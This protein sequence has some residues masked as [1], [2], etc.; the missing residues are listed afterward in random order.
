MRDRNRHACLATY[1]GAL[2]F[3]FVETICLHFALTFKFVPLDVVNNLVN[4]TFSA[5]GK[6]AQRLWKTIETVK[7]KSVPVYE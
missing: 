4:D 3:A 5:V 2:C 7:K 6:T 1:L